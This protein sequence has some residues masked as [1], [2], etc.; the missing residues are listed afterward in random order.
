MKQETRGGKRAGAGRKAKET[1]DKRVNM[2]VTVDRE[3]RERLRAISK[4][5]NTRPG[6]IIDEMVKE[7]W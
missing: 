1:E 3:T 7:E 5:R 6:K 4:A 2:V